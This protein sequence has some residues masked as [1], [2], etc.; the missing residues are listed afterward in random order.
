MSKIAQLRFV[1]II[2][3]LV[4]S[5]ALLSAVQ[6]LRAAPGSFGLT[7]NVDPAGKGSVDVN[8]PPP[9][10]ENQVVTLTATPIAG[11]TFDKWN[12]QSDLVWWN[13]D[14]DYR[15]EVS[16]G[17][18][19]VARKNKPAEF[20][21][22]FSQIW[23]SLGK[24]GT[25][26][27]NSLRVVEVGQ[28]D[29]VID[30]AV[31]FQFDKAA[32]YNAASKAAGTLT[33]IMQ[34]NTPAGATRR[35]HVYFD[36]TGKG[37]APP[38]VTPQ[39]VFSDS[40]TDESKPAFRMVTPVGTYFYHTRGGGFSS[41]DDLSGNDWI[42]WNSAAGNAGDFRGIPNLVT[43]NNGGTFHPGRNYMKTTLVS[44]GPIKVTFISEEAKTFAF[45]EEWKGMWEIYPTYAKFT[46]L[47]APYDYWF[48][49]EGT[50][51]GAL[52]PATDFV[53]RSD[54]T[55]TS[56]GTA[57]E[58]DIA[59]EEWAY[60]ADPGVGRALFLASHTDDNKIDSYGQQQNI[61]TKF[62]FGR[63]GA[64]PQIDKNIL[65]RQFTWG[66]M[67][68]TVYDDAK[69][70]IY[71]AYRDLNT[72][73]GAAAARAGA[74][75]G[76]N[77]PVEFTI[78]GQHII[79]AVFKPIQYT[80]TVAAS[81]ADKGT[82]T[83]T[84]NKATYDAGEE[85]TLAAAPVAGWVFAGWTG[86]VTG[87][88][89][90]VTVPVNKNMTVTA[91]FAQSFTITTSVNP[92][93]S[94]SV[95]L[96]PNKATY[97][98]GEQ[99]EV[100][101]VANSGFGFTNWSGDLSGTETS[102]TI[103]VNGNLNIVANFS[104]AQFT[105]DATANGNGA[106]DWAPKK[107]LYGS[108]EV[109]VVTATAAEGY[110]FTG[111]TGDRT[112]T[113]NPLEVTITSNT[114]IVGNFAPIVYYTVNTST[115]GAGTVI[116]NPDLPE[117]AAGSVV[118]L[119]AVPAA[120][121]R[122]VGW[123]GTVSGTEET[124]QV[125]VT[126]NVTAVATF[127]SDTYPLN[128]TIV[129]EGGVSKLPDQAEGYL[130]GQ[131][132]T[133]TATAAPGWTFSEWSGAASGTAP[134]TTVTIDG[135]TEVT[136][137]F[138]P[139]GPFTLSVSAAGNGSGTVE[140]SP[141]KATYAWGEQ[142]TLTA[143]PGPDSVFAGW[144][145]DATSNSNPLVL[146]MDSD[147]AVVA[148]FIVPTGPF[149]DN[150]NT[151][152]LAT[153]WGQP[154]NP[155]GDATFTATGT[156]LEIHVPEGAD[157]NIWKNINN[158]PRILQSAD[159]KDFEVIAK[160]DSA[161]TQPAQ[162]Q[163]IVVQQDAN[164]LIRFDFNYLNGQVNA[165]AATIT[166]GAARKRLELPIPASD[167]RYLKVTRAGDNWAV[168]FSANGTVWQ[169]AGNFNYTIT[170]RQAGVFAGNVRPDKNSTAPAFTAQIDYFYNSAE[171]ALPEDAPLLKVTIVGGGTVN[172]NPSIEQLT[173]GQTAILTAAPGLGYQFAGWSGD[174]TGAQNPL[175][176]LVNR[177]RA[178][179]ATF[180]GSGARYILLPMITR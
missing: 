156:H 149:S 145:G 136:A 158:A 123:S 1:L 107:A 16:A 103:V 113:D 97:Q 38:N 172:V 74:S 82:V 170:V 84:P 32:D 59:N 52:Q 124:I 19:G 65:P 112:A 66:I 78:T 53:V 169:P 147:K 40:V 29:S 4:L 109:V 49:Y 162:I 89:N 88:T 90:P 83:K 95:T 131:V 108:G 45:R 126:G 125:T 6:P 179:T 116:K 118:T 39:I 30:D 73:V 81:P 14:W 70:I 159:N 26:D 18:A 96:N 69:P 165:Y 47:V 64:S 10:S 58:A 48:L 160:F 9:Y 7:V 111:W 27:P 77:N 102:K 94:G 11:W 134:S 35:Y 150:F 178:V 161:V 75:L 34:G 20:S 57:W 167:A 120:Q 24:S 42:S 93:G 72:T 171:P 22:N 8:P 119:T 67:D 110:Y 135:P 163:G 141:E 3:A 133:L 177:P 154:F 54:G 173:C 152:N 98:P 115:V 151:C 91:M 36:V 104:A 15:V 68:T 5:T 17:A 46:L 129:G 63:S 148:N 146:T 166:D 87:T 62:A 127:E 85:V 168:A 143:D 12:L 142:V 155:T 80:V 60:V 176:V 122:F 139:L 99:V 2:G 13:N 100:T 79:T 61:M 174:A 76:S 157:H 43:P 140:I 37:F 137:T 164:N 153:M 25:F 138:S 23:S 175:Q 128:V 130:L 41:F 101:A 117:Y 92:P 121:S 180:T 33:L 86:D 44:A 106:V 55:Q 31:P 56:A 144:S 28:N 132:V 114:S 21:L 50:P 71:N 51:G 105:F